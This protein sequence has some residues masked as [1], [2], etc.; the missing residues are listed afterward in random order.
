MSCVAEAV[1]QAGSWVAPIQPS[2]WEPPYAKGAALKGQKTKQ[3]NTT[4]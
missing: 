1:A 4:P 2:A 3:K